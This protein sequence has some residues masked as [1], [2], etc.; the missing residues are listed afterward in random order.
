MWPSEKTTTDGRWTSNG[1][2]Q[3][4]P[5]EPEVLRQPDDRRREERPD[6]PVAG[7]QDDERAPVR[8]LWPSE[9][10][11]LP[12]QQRRQE[13]RARRRH[14]DERPAQAVAQ[15]RDAPAGRCRSP[16]D[17]AGGRQAV[18]SRSLHAAGSDH[19]RACGRVGPCLVLDVRNVGFV[20][21][22]CAFQGR[23]YW[24]IAARPLCGP[25]SSIRQPQFVPAN[26]LFVPGTGDPIA[27]NRTVTMF[28]RHEGRRS[29]FGGNADRNGAIGV[30]AVGDAGRWHAAS[31]ARRA[32]QHASSRRSRSS[33]R[34]GCISLATQR[35]V[36]LA[37]SRERR[38]ASIERILT[39]SRSLRHSDV[40]PLRSVDCLLARPSTDG[41]KSQILRELV[42][43]MIA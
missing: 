28:R 24:R 10:V 36:A 34:V 43:I 31:A 26:R 32:R 12:G 2:P 20:L 30:E 19:E 17:R 39:T 11:K 35:P 1:A 16:G 8:R 29:R 15:R 41:R 3:A 13:R 23:K 42:C 27:R 9:A 14:E 5:L 7:V 21:S 37:R 18:S 22:N 38:S 25:T 4:L 6:V 40:M 33:M